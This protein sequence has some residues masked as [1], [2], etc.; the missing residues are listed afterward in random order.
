MLGGA[1]K[2]FNRESNKLIFPVNTFQSPTV[3]TRKWFFVLN[4]VAYLLKEFV[5]TPRVFRY[6]LCSE[7]TGVLF[8]P[9]SPRRLSPCFPQKRQRR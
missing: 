5:T 7:G 6:A 9:S 4:L 8:S 1:V 2:S 3:D